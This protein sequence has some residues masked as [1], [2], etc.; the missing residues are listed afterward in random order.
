MRALQRKGPT[1]SQRKALVSFNLLTVVQ[2]VAAFP[3]PVAGW[4]LGTLGTNRGI[5]E[6]NHIILH[7][8][9]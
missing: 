5:R 6:G 8:I 2:G 4:A 1:G 9:R 7:H 3:F